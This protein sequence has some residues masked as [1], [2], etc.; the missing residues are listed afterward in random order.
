MTN[1][2]YKNVYRT[3]TAQTLQNTVFKE[4][5][6]QNLQNGY[7]QR[8]SGD[9][10]I[11]HNPATISYPIKGSTHGSAYIYDTH[12]PVIFYGKGIKKG[13]SKNYIPII[14]IAP[15]LS[16][17]LHISFPNGNTGKIIK[18]ALK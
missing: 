14:D 13:V 18:G 7:N 9:V 10:F 3:V 5:V 2:N 16:N 11:I 6:L 15:T 12:V 4:R 8:L 17:L 1:T